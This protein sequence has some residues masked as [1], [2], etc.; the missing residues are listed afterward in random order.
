MSF[1]GVSSL[2][3]KSSEAEC[4]KECEIATTFT[5]QAE[6]RISENLAAVHRN[7]DEQMKNLSDHVVQSEGYVWDVL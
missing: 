3:E 7:E 1:Q 2:I 6:R 4:E 5:R